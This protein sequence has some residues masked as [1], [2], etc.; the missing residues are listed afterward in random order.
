MDG[1]QSILKMLLLID[2]MKLIQVPLVTMGRLSGHNKEIHPPIFGFIFFSILLGSLMNFTLWPIVFFLHS[3]GVTICVVHVGLFLDMVAWIHG[4]HWGH[5]LARRG[6]LFF[7]DHSYSIVLCHS[8]GHHSNQ[9][10]QDNISWWIMWGDLHVFP[11]Y[12]LLQ[13]HQQPMKTLRVAI[14]DSKGRTCVCICGIH[15]VLGSL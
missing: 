4:G 8:T 3:L 14:C 12:I 5:T 2:L 11:Q 10:L 13:N 15:V 1:L 6:Q 9:H 7:A